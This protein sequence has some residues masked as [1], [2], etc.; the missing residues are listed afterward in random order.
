MSGLA[1]RL[2]KGALVF[3]L[4]TTAIATA[5][6]FTIVATCRMT[7]PRE[8][9]SA[10]TGAPRAEVTT[11]TENAARGEVVTR[12]GASWMRMR[13]G[14]R[15][16]HL[17]GDARAIGT[18][19]G[20]LLRS[21]MIANETELWGELDRVVPVLPA[22]LLLLDLGRLRYRHVDR[23]IPE[24]RRVEIGAEAAALAPDPFERRLPSYDR[25]ILLH[26][27]YDIALSFEHSPLV[28]CS[29]FGLGPEAT[30]DGH[31]LLARAF[32]FEAGEVF[33]RDKAVFFVKSPGTI[34]FA[35]VAWPGLVGVVSG[36]NAEGLA[37]VVHGGRAG[38]PRTE[39]LPVTFSMRET[40]ERAHDVDEAVAIL[41]A[42]PVMVS[43]VVVLADAK[44]NF[45]VVE[46]APGVETFVRRTFADPHR[47]GVTNHFEGPLAADPKNASVRARTTTLARRARLDELL[48]SVGPR[49]ADAARAVEMLRDH[50][51]AG[52]EACPLG[53]RRSIDAFIATHGIVAD[54][55]SRTLWVSAG[56]QLSGAFV[57]F[58]LTR[59]FGPPDA[60]PFVIDAREPTT[61]APD[62]PRPPALIAAD[63]VRSDMRYREGRERALRTRGEDQAVKGAAP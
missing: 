8:P 16:V 26:S 40:L 48:R 1:S 46:R 36:M 6:H 27:L 59:D 13:H 4:G 25:L 57:G 18:A 47:V 3:A 43:H 23:G 33:D 56:P 15:E 58:D 12:Y 34:P 35:S 29:T 20:T 37:A 50:A 60:L 2:A 51:C 52:G 7:P 45:A 11:T 24:A 41:T 39:G 32:D 55:T 19:H 5:A 31:T 30:R 49:Q 17:E 14:V 61:L 53:D 42:Q 62:S 28:G 9:E 22:R 10:S 21:A 44:A 63:P 38:E 54:T